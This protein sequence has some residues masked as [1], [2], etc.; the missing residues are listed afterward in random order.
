R[1]IS[2]EEQ[3]VAD[4][5][6][7]LNE[8][9]AHKFD[10]SKPGFRLPTEFEWEFANR[11]PFVTPFFFG[12]DRTLIEDYAHMNPGKP[13]STAV[14]QH[15]PS[16]FGLF[17]SYGNVW[18]WCLD[19]GGQF[20]EEEDVMDPLGTN[21]KINTKLAKGGAWNCGPAWCR[22]ASRA[23]E[24]PRSWLNSHGFRIAVTLPQD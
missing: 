24:T 20:R 21:E 11:G 10:L 6:L 2:K 12:S 8:I 16:P 7:Q 5:R 9:M 19:W 14:G 4:F 22:T 3:V 1:G 13:F 17:D 15:C 23:A 18:E